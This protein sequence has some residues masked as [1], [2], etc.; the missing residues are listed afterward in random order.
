MVKGGD[1]RGVEDGHPAIPPTG[2]SPGRTGAV[3]F[4]WRSAL[5]AMPAI[6]LLLGGGLLGSDILSAS[7]LAGSAFSVGFTASREVAGRRWAMPV[8]TTVAMTLAAFSGTLAGRQPI[9]ELVLVS[10]AGG[11]TGAL[12]TRNM[13][14]WW[15]GLQATIALVVAAH[16]AGDTAAAMHRAVLVGAGGAVQGALLLAAMRLF[17]A[18]ALVAPAPATPAPWRDTGLHGLRAAVCV[19]GALAAAHAFGLSHAYWAPTTALIVLKPGLR[20]TGWR[21]L[22]RLAGTTAGLVLATG[23]AL[24]FAGQPWLL[25]ATVVLAAGAAFGLQRARYAVLTS[26]ITV[27]ALMLTVLAGA[28]V[29]STDVDRLAATLL[30]GAVAL[31]GAGLAPRRLPWRRSADDRA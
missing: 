15:I 7:I 27:T 6:A 26:A 21:G 23:F 1:K 16:F 20:D 24:M 28:P 14:Y 13:T 29:L 30:G 5:L 31:L 10:L 25:A 4:D 12:A 19:G 17:G 22:E 2:A 8:L 9:P 3:S 18:P 11:A